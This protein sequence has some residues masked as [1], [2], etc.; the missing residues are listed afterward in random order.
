[1]SSN[2][3]MNQL[4]DVFWWSN[5]T[6]QMNIQPNDILSKLVVLVYCLYIVMITYP[7]SNLTS[8]TERNKK[9]S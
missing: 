2:R 1:M 4:I 5:E 7:C 3:N 6:Q 9:I 8:Y